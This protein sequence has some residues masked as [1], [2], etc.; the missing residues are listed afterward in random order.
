[1]HLTNYERE[2]IIT[3][4]EAD[5]TA[6]VYTCNNALI[7]KLDNLCAESKEFLI[8]REDEYSKTYELPKKYVSIRAPYKMSEEQRKKLS[9]RAKEQFTHKDNNA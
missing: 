8:V 4:N 3:Y 1:M 2:T 5:K 7:R 6:Q 9:E